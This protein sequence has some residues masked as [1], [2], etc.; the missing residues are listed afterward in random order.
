M[1]HQI[2]QVLLQ[3]SLCSYNLFVSDPVYEFESRHRHRDAL[4]LLAVHLVAHQV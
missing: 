2:S 4:L 3:D 1:C